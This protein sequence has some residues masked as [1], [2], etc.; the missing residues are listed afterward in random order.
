V[1]SDHIVQYL[2]GRA[3][4][5]SKSTV[6]GIVSILRGMGEYLVRQEVWTSSPLRWMR[7]PKLDWQRQ[8]P[9]RIGRKQME[10]LWQTA[11][12][13]RSGYRRYL[14]TTLLAMLYGTGLRRGE[15]ARLDVSAWEES[16]GTL[17]I[18]G[19]KTR[20]QRQVRLPTL[21][22]RCL[23]VYLPQRYNQL[24]RLGR[25]DEPALWINQD[26]ERLS[27]AS[28][29][30]GIARIADRGGVGH[31]TLH[32][33]RHSCASDLLE[34]GTHLPEIQ[35]LLGHQSIMTTVRYLQVADPQRHQAAALHPINTM[36]TEL[37]GVS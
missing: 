10:T 4:F 5:K 14:W 7:G 11:A 20:C 24:Q 37:G 23:S 26:G 21:T 17:L 33:F 31:I 25:T 18:D 3:S 35:R 13:H 2:Q 19:H 16:A 12:T 9:R 6:A 8:A 1:G 36:L 30:R 32:Q 22:A 27:K 15:L 29:S 28:I 34:A